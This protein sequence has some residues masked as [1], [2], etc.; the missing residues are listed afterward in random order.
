MTVKERLLEFALIQNGMFPEQAK[1]VFQ[2]ALPKLQPDNYRVTWNQPAGD[3]PDAMYAIWTM[4]I[5]PIALEWILTN[6]PMA[7][8]RPMFTDN[9]EEEIARLTAETA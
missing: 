1:Q 4:T 3:Y 5:K 2:A 6:C 7:W 8:F 9:P